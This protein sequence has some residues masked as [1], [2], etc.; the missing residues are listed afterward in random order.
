VP[1]SFRLSEKPLRKGGD[2]EVV[3][4]VEERQAFACRQVAILSSKRTN[5]GHS[6]S[7]TILRGNA[8]IK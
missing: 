8:R 6:D 4:T 5:I 3:K 1:E 2:S 7:A